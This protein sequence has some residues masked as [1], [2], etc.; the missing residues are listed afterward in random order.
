MMGMLGNWRGRLVAPAM[1]L[2]I[3]GAAIAPAATPSQAQVWGPW[4]PLPGWDT[5]LPGLPGPLGGTNLGPLLGPGAQLGPVPVL[6]PT[7]NR[8]LGAFMRV[9]RSVS[10]GNGADATSGFAEDATLWISDGV[11][12]C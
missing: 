6:G 4:G 10:R 9:L 1:A 8:A 12:L 7:E 11:G 2:G 5:D 3:L